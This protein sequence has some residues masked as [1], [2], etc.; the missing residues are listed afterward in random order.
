MKGRRVKSLLCGSTG[1]VLQWDPL[2]TSMCDVLVQHDDGTECAHPSN[3]LRPIDGLGPLPSRLEARIAADELALTRLEK[4]R[5]D[6]I[7][8]FHKPWPG[9]EHGKALVGMGITG[10]IEDIKARLAVVKSKMLL[11]EGEKP[12]VN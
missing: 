4:I 6:H 10:A 1:T 12:D 9:C 3:N 11:P 8:D 5:D 7:R 2:T